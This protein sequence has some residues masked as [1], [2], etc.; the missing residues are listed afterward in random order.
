MAKTRAVSAAAAA[1]ATAAAAAAAAIAGDPNAG[2]PMLDHVIAVVL[3]QPKDGTLAKVLDRGGISKVYNVL[4]LT[5]TDHDSLTFVDVDG[6]VTPPPSLLVF[7]TCSRWSESMAPF[8]QSKEG[9]S[10]TGWRLLRPSLMNSGAAPN[11]SMPPS[12][13]NQSPLPPDRI[14]FLTF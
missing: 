13:K 12:S 9:P 14:H 4:I 2:K 6:L 8:A 5:Q 11:A 7:E 10:P 3:N 1:A